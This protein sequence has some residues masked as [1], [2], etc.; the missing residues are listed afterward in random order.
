M[1]ILNENLI[2]PAGAPTERRHIL[3]QLLLQM[4]KLTAEQIDKV[5]AHQKR[6]DCTFG[7]AAIALGFVR[8]VDIMEALARQYH[9]PILS[10][11]ADNSAL[12]SELVIGHDPFGTAA[13]TIRSIRSAV[14]HAALGQGIRSIMI[15]APARGAGSTY[16]AGNLALSLAQMNVKTL[17]VDADM[18]DPRVGTMFGLNGRSKGL[19]EAVRY[20]DEPV[21]PYSVVP[22][23]SVL[24]SGAVPP[25]PQEL[26]SS[27]EFLNLSTRFEQEYGAVIYDTAPGIEFAD[28]QIIAARVGTAIVV[29]RQ[30][31]TRFADVSA[32][33]QKLKNIEC[34][35]I[36][37][38]FNRF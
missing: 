32:L 7:D 23:L 37:T 20:P 14:V 36:G 21:M 34:N 29:A 10:G 18:R 6:Q 3:G 5:L 15:T 27:V 9:Y 8:R 26:L 2:T 13:E 22:S 24:P 35:V 17:L 12:S 4:G 16:L 25:N 11:D 19:S 33:A 30:H 28:V 38:V 1:S 31:V